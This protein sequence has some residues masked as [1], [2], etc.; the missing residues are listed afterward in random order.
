[1]N[2]EDFAIESVDAAT[3]KKLLGIKGWFLKGEKRDA[4]LTSKLVEK[5]IK[6]KKK[7]GEKVTSEEIDK[8]KFANDPIFKQKVIDKVHKDCDKKYHAN[9][10]KCENDIASLERAKTHEINRI[11]ASRW[12][13]I[14]VKDVKYNMTEGKLLLNGTTALFSSIKGAAANLNESYRVETH[15]TGKSK[16]HAS[17]G[18]AVVG[19]LMFGAVG[20]MV[21]GTALGKTTHQI[22]A[23]T[24]TIPT[25]NHFGIVVDLDGFKSEIVLLNHTVDQDSDEFRK[26]V[27]KAQVIISKLQYLSTVPVPESFLRPDEEPSVIELQDKILAAHKA[28][29]V[30][31]ADV[32]TYEIPERYL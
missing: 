18:G 15:E 16:K 17:I 3:E 10:K 28:L 29:D 25:A 30:A 6:D 1:M 26:A 11:E 5:A 8:I 23:N 20:A 27:E 19:G 2:T 24:N 22:D 12:E 7:A 21:G 9:I 4:L 32:P 31:K 14:V 13:N